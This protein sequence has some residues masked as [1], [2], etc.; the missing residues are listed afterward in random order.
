VGKLEGGSAC[1]DPGGLQGP[2]LSSQGGSW[3]GCEG[4]TPTSLL[5]GAEAEEEE[6]EVVVV[7]TFC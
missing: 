3:L 4:R 7:F 6:D 2:G 5:K 1:P